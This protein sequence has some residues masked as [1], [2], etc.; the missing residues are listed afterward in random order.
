MV[1]LGRVGECTL[2]ELRAWEISRLLGVY[3]TEE[4]IEEAFVKCYKEM[5]P[6]L[7]FGQDVQ[8]DLQTYEVEQKDRSID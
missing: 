7:Q 8:R 2:K 5:H 6:A 1:H 3:F 4:S